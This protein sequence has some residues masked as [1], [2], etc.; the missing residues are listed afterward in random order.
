MGERCFECQGFKTRKLEKKKKKERNQSRLKLE[1]FSVAAAVLLGGQ[2]IVA[3]R[4]TTSLNVTYPSVLDEDRLEY[5]L[6]LTPD[7]LPEMEEL[8][9]PGP[10]KEEIKVEVSAF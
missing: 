4:G 7:L 2:Y 9:L 6:Y 8:L 5:R 10:L 3:G 1:L